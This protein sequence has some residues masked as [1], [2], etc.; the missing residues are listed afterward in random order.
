[1]TSHDRILKEI[2]KEAFRQLWDL[3]DHKKAA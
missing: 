2:D 3:K 1:M